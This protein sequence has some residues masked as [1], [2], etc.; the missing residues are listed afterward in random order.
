MPAYLLQWTAIQDA[1]RYGCPVYD[2]YGMPPTDDPSHPMHGLYLFKTGFGGTIV[3]R[4]GSF[5]VP[6]RPVM[7]KAYIVAERM[8]AFIFKKLVK[9]LH[10]R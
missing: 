5:D 6:V 3:H 9:K 2:F 10:R 7:Y 4:P 1:K 8:R